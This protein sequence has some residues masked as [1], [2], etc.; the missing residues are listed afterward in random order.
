MTYFFCARV[1]RGGLFVA[2]LLLAYGN[3]AHAEVDAFKPLNRAAPPLAL[4]DLQGNL[5]TRDQ[6][7]GKVVIV[8]F[9][10]TWCEPC[11]EEMP[12]LARLSSRF[13]AEKIIV[14][15]VNLREGESRIKAFAEKNAVSFPLLMDRDGVAKREWKVQGAP[16]TYVLDRT[17]RVRYFYSGA[18]DFSSSRIEQQIAGL[19]NNNPDKRIK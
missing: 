4:K 6:Y 8:N 9:W 12:S 16:A 15:G 11:L 19:I 13:P 2:I 1:L 7:L 3:V 14:L 18:L 5:H 17:G 10:A